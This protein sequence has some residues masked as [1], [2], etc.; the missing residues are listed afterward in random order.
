M[1]H[2]FHSGGARS[3]TVAKTKPKHSWNLKVSME[4]DPA[5]VA[6]LGKSFNSIFAGSRLLSSSRG[7]NLFV[8]ASSCVYSFGLLRPLRSPD[9]SPL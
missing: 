3:Y 4:T 1:P 8:G 2:P 9:G 6:K 5:R 7:G